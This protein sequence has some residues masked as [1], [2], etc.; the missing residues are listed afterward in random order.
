MDSSTKETEQNKM[1]NSKLNSKLE[2]TLKQWK[3]ILNKELAISEDL[4]KKDVISQ[5]R[6]MIKKVE[7]MMADNSLVKLPY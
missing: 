7:E 2:T 4:R 1:K 6:M 3:R 5:A